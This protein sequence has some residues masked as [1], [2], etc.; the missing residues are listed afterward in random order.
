MLLPQE[1]LWKKVVQG[2]SSVRSPGLSEHR[3]VWAEL[4]SECVELEAKVGAE[5]KFVGSR[6]QRPRCPR[7]LAGFRNAKGG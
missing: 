6:G 2:F 7:G 5:M 4:R 3:T 1:D